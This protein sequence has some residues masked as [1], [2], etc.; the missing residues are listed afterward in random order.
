MQAQ[1]TFDTGQDPKPNGKEWVR[2]ENLSD[3]FNGNS[4]NDTKWQTEPVENGW[5]WIG[6]PPGLFEKE[7]VSVSGGNLRV[8]V[9]KFETPK[10]RNGTTF[11][12]GGGIV[13]SI[14]S[15]G[16]GLYYE[17]RMKAN[18]T[19]MSS[20]FWLMTKNNNCNQ[21][22]EIDIQECVGNTTPETFNFARNWDQIFHSN[23]ISRTTSC[24]PNPV[25]KQGSVL[26]N[27][28][29]HSRYFVYGCWWKSPSE[30]RFYLDGKFVYK[31]TPGRNFN[32]Q[33][34]IHM[35]M[36]TYDWNPVP[37]NGGKVASG[38]LSERITSYDWVRTWKLKDAT[39]SG[40]G[41][42]S[43]VI[44]KKRNGNVAIDGNTGGADG[45][46]LKIWAL[47]NSNF[48]R[49]WEE[50]DR[51]NGFFSYKKRGTNYCIDGGNGGTANQKVKL[52]L[53]GINNQNQHWKKIDLGNGYFR[54]QKRNS[55]GFS[56]HAWGNQ[57]G[58]LLRLKANN[59]NDQNMQ[60]K[61]NSPQQIA[62]GEYFITSTTSDQRLL[63]R[64]NE[65]YSAIMY[66]PL[67]FNDQKWVFNHLGENVYTIK[68]LENNRYLEV[69]YA[70]CSNGENVATWTDAS[71]N[72]QKW[73]VVPDGNGIYSLKP[74]HCQQVALDREDGAVNANVQ[75]WEYSMSNMNQKWRIL[76][77][78]N[79]RSFDQIKDG[80]SIE[81]FPNP[82]NDFITV[83]GVEKG[84]NIKIYDILGKVVHQTLVKNENESLS[85]SSLKPGLY[86]VSYD[87]RMRIS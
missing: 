44:I 63:S 35:A 75:V 5:V 82:A 27:T 13:R 87:L 30:L 19:E 32:A 80:N 51:G 42:N 73:K 74:M 34:F 31:I 55:P 59:D 56:L 1:P 9:K 4:I 3:E 78:A 54:L 47:S 70:K 12:Y 37:A 69:P 62:N 81:I 58:N 49:Q 36:E 2:V 16:L 60:W 61:F 14:A 43:F 48:N 77:A 64:Q 40:G 18:A 38:S 15:G 17:A 46:D 28:K 86:I 41:S 10:I 66:S 8:Q 33:A 67:N 23:A 21:K 83:T 39:P 7:S 26:T 11:L 29:N 50:I 68:N 20:T 85:T 53:S 6:R 65:Q 45:R 84:D 72:H 22:N 57:N 52:R 76:P 25:Q 79:S 71:A 24:F